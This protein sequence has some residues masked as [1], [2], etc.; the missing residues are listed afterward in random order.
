MIESHSDSDT[1]IMEKYL[2]SVIIYCLKANIIRYTDNIENIMKTVYSDEI[3]TSVFDKLGFCID[4]TESLEKSIHLE[5][6]HK[7]YYAATILAM[8]CIEHLLNE[9][10]KEY[11]EEKYE[12][13]NAQIE[14]LLKSN[15]TSEKVG[16]LFVVT[17][18]REFS[19]PIKGE[20]L[21]LNK[22]RNSFIHYKM[23]YMSWDEV[24]NDKS[25][26]EIKKIALES[27]LLITKLREYLEG[28]NKELYPIRNQAKD[29]FDK[30][31]STKEENPNG[32]DE[33]GNA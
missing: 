30:I 12:M 20:I 13:S 5:L 28:I 10:Y 4:Y 1:Y 11:L 33:N 25:D 8:T 19:A 32:K 9:F 16:G 24:D 6:E 21:N 26:I 15:S 2:Y 31:K 17:F 29:I 3:W 23:K 22:K 18:N 27:P 7:Q 14:S